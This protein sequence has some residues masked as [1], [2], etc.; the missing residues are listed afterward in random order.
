MDEQKRGARSLPSE[1]QHCI[2]ISDFRVQK[3][4]FSDFCNA[5]VSLMFL[6]FIRP[7]PLGRLRETKRLPHRPYQPFTWSAI[8]LI[9][10]AISSGERMKSMQPLS[11]ALCGISG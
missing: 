11:I 5:Q 6:A 9:R 8:S 1:I 4:L 7:A 10:F 3:A 2:R